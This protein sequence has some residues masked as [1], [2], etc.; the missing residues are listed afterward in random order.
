MIKTRGSKGFDALFSRVF[1][2][3][4]LKGAVESLHDDFSQLETDLSSLDLV[5]TSVTVSDEIVEEMIEQSGLTFVSSSVTESIHLTLDDV[6]SEIDPE[7]EPEG[8]S[9]GLADGWSIKLFDEEAVAPTEESSI[10]EPF[11]EEPFDEEPFDEEPLIEEPLVEEPVIAPALIEEPK[12]DPVT[13]PR[14]DPSPPLSPKAKWMPLTESQGRI[15]IYLY[16]IAGGLSSVDIIA[17]ELDLNSSTVREALLVLVKD[18]YLYLLDKKRTAGTNGFTYNMNK[19]L[20]SIYE[21]RLRGY[22]GL[23]K[24]QS[25]ASS[26][27]RLSVTEAEPSEGRSLVFSSRLLDEKETITSQT[28]LY[29]AVGAYWKGEGLE[30]LQIQKWCSQFGVEPEEMRQQL[31]WARFDLEFNKRRKTVTNNLTTWFYDHLRTN[32]GMFPRPAGYRSAGELRAEA[33]Q[34]QRES[35]LFAKAKIAEIE[36]AN[37]L[38]SFLADPDAPLYRELLG[39][40][41]AF[42]LEQ[43]K[44]GK[45]QAARLELEA[46]FK[47]HWSL[48]YNDSGTT[49]VSFALS[50]LEPAQPPLCGTSPSQTLICNDS[51]SREIP[52]AIGWNLVGYNAASSRSVDQAVSSISTL[53]ESIWGWS[54]ASGQWHSYAPDREGNS[55]T[56]LEPGMGYWIKMKRGATWRLPSAVAAL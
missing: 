36:F 49:T 38:Q 12:P 16:E 8:E 44:G 13:P 43:L 9:N 18:G 54:S 7:D 21:A 27:G 56:T 10:E 23:A 26:I 42:A 15:L 52:L 19:H 17:K 51:G 24:G 28:V 34:Q 45:G 48:T 47:I 35:G 14:K 30:E 37:S 33:M 50:G 4:G 5:V 53:I 46:L 31:E 3:P 40:V 29:G 2:E 39:R 20:C 32:G 41:N 55:L 1:D 25:L 11:D 6:V 22:A